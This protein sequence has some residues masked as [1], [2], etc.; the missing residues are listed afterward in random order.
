MRQQIQ[1]F[2]RTLS[3]MVMPN[4]GAFIAWGFITAL[5][6]PEGWWPNGQLAQLVGPMLT[7]LLPLLIAYTAGRNVAGERGGV[8]GAIAAVGVIVGSDIPMFIGAMIMGPLAGYAIRRFD[9]MVEG[10]VKAG[11]EMLVSNFSIG[12]LGMLL[13]VLGYYVVGSVVSGLTMLI[14]S[15]AELVIRHGLL[16]LVSLFVEPAKVL[17]LNNAVNHGIFSPIGIEQARE[18]GQS[19]MFL[20]ETNPGPG[21]GV[22]LAYWLFGRGNARQSAPGAVIIQFFGGIHEIYF[23]YILARPVLI[24]A[25]IAGSAAGLLFFSLTDAGLVAPASPG[26]ILSVLAMAPKGKTLIVL[27]GVVISAAVS[28]LVAAPFIRR[29]SK[30][31]TEGDPAVGKLPQSA[32]GISPHAAGR[33]VR[34]VIFACDAGMGSSALGATRFRR[35]LRDAGIGVA[36]GN[37]AADR[38]PSDADVVV[39]QSVLAERIAAAAKGAELI[40]IDNFL[41]DPGLDA[42]FVRLAETT[43]SCGVSG[44]RSAQSALSCDQSGLRDAAADSD[45]KPEETAF[46]PKDA[47]PDGA[48]LQPGNIRIGLPAEPKEEAIRRAGELLVAGGYARPEYVDAML[49]REELAT[50]C[51]GMGLAIPHGTSDAK[52]RVLRSG[53]VILQYPDGVDFDGEKAHLIVGIAGVGDEHLEILA[54]LSASFEDEE[55]LQRLMTATDPQV[56]YDALK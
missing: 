21:L 16:P 30:T 46:A 17:F 40:V 42:L 52:E 31:E 19:I 25:A 29:A 4:I 22:L 41:S 11:F 50:T 39:C 38:I 28:L 5:F 49:R 32:A 13:A 43:P 26:S 18:T 6:I 1:Q 15:G 36:V 8:I 48:I 45:P 2:G 44:S 20:L 54:R 10:R 27:L 3:G 24:V 9:R 14:S 55:L 7:Y 56:I 33:P 37:S 51:L 23:P 34:K 53:I 35:R 47:A 12:I